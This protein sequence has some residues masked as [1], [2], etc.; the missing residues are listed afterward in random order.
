MDDERI[1]QVVEQERRSLADLL[2]SLAPEQWDAPTMCDGWRVREVAAHLTIAARLTVPQMVAGMVRARGD[3]NRFVYEDGRRRGAR[4]SAELVAELR[5]LAASRRHPRPTKPIDPMV[6]VLV[7]GQ[8]I[9]TAVG[10]ERSMPRDAAEAGAQHVWESTF[11]FA[12]Q[13]RLAGQRLVATDG[14]WSVGEGPD[15]IEAPIDRLLLLLTGRLQP[16][17]VAAR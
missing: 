11:P 1:W 2:E 14:D 3:F 13:R 17:D 9:A 16:E 12:A 15:V 4:P 7:H 8:D 5:S 10:V 6:D